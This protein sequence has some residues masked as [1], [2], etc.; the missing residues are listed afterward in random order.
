MAESTHK[1][2]DCMRIDKPREG[3]PAFVKAKIGI[4][5]E[6]FTAYLQEH[7]NGNGFVDIDVLESRD[8]EKL[9]GALND[10]KPETSAQPSSRAAAPIEYPKDDINPEDIPF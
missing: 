8:G 9:Y 6:K 4:N 5:V 7:A 1:F 3:A 2:I 10:W